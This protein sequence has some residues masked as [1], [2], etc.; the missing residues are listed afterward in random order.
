MTGWVREHGYGG[1]FNVH[2]LEERGALAWRFAVSG[3]REVAAALA[4]PRICGHAAGEVLSRSFRGCANAKPPDTPHWDA[5]WERRVVE[6]CPEGAPGWQRGAWPVSSSVLPNYFTRGDEGGAERGTYSRAMIAVANSQKAGSTTLRVILSKMCGAAVKATASNATRPNF[7]HPYG[8]KQCAEDE[9]YEAGACCAGVARE[10]DWASRACHTLI[11][12]RM[13]AL[14]GECGEGYAS[15]AQ[16]YPPGHPATAPKAPPPLVAVHMF[17]EPI[18]RLVSAFRYCTDGWTADALCG[19]YI[20]AYPN[21]TASTSTNLITFASHWSSYE[22]RRL[23]DNA[24]LSVD[25]SAQH[26]DCVHVRG[27]REFRDK[28]QQSLAQHITRAGGLESMFSVIGLL[29]E[30][31]LSLELY[32]EVTGLPFSAFARVAT[33]TGGGPLAKDKPDPGEETDYAPGGTLLLS[34]ADLMSFARGSPDILSYLADDLDIYA[35]A[36]ELFAKQV[37]AYRKKEGP[38]RNQLLPPRMEAVRPF[39]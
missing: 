5:S 15:C 1:V 30:E 3:S 34:T 28:P 2:W 20:K 36:K 19:M 27:N 37:E 16:C 33:N 23:L 25:C 10:E 21:Q 24:L 26:A 29:S 35:A 13:L 32:S 11:G 18:E 9:A 31:A 6:D 17:R 14:S 4:V 22:T 12:D 8:P 38:E 39:A 7:K